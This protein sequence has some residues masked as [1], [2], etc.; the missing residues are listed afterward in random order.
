MD[1][2]DFGYLL[3]DKLGAYLI[4]LGV[5]III[6]FLIFRKLYLSF[7]D[8][9][10]FSLFISVFGFS[11]V[12]FL[13]VTDKIDNI[14]LFNYLLTQIAY[15]IG[16]FTF[17]QLNNKTIFTSY[18][19]KI[20]KDQNT[21][22]KFF[23]L[24]VTFFYFIFQVASFTLVGIPL[25]MSSHVDTYSNSGGLG[26][27]GRFLD[28]LKPMEIFILCYL[29]IFSKENFLFRGFSWT[30]MGL[31]VISLLLSGSKSQFLLMGQILF[32]FFI[33]NAT[34]LIQRYKLLKKIE[35]ITAVA[36][37]FIVLG[38]FAVQIG[39]R[40]DTSVFKAFL[41]RLVASGDVYHFA[42]VK[43]TIEHIDGG[44]AMLALFGNILGT[45]RL[46]PRE[47]IPNPL[48]L[49]LYNYYYV[50][51]TIA[52]PNARINVFG[53]VYFGFIGSII[54]SYLIGLFAGF[55]R[56]K[57]FFKLRSSFFGQLFF[58]L[59]YLQTMNMETDPSAA[60]ANIENILLILPVIL[61]LM[62]F[63]YFIFAP[64]N[65]YYA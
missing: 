27:L 25:F 57:L 19:E 31:V 54:F 50:S 15:W 62:F 14:Y 42:Y 7:L 35:K 44:N 17:K 41:F 52:G 60:V 1:W 4:C 53:Y 16:F 43:H 34:K 29:F 49:T 55:V 18:T 30:V 51:D 59:L 39:E 8:P 10:I 38:I 13:S 40:Q 22:I 12:I 26:F 21:L 47:N 9:L 63:G 11:L 48:G 2:V 6:Y 3:N 56:N 32:I 65:K 23:F 45:L 28:V 61:F 46:V 36:G 20:F 37:L 58:T 33:L 5:S 64:R 24:I